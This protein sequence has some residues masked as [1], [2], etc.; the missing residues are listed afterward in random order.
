MHG[1]E[2]KDME[3]VKERWEER[4]RKKNIFIFDEITFIKVNAY[5]I[6][7]PDSFCVC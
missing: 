4:K 6:C 1:I 5:E 7:E 2:E 3:T